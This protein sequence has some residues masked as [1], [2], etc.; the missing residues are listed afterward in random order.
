[1]GRT[2][3]VLGRQDDAARYRALFE[4]IRAAFVREFVTPAGRVGE[5]TRTAYVLALQFD[6]LPDPMRAPA[7]ERL[8]REVRE[9]GHLT[10]GFTGTPVPRAQPLRVPEGGLATAQPARVP[11]VAVPDHAGRHDDLGALG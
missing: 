2:A 5:N 6:L 9:R 7:A 3:Q 11:V 1:M 4:R 8:A 10:T